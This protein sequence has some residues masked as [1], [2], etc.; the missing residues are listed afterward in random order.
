[1]IL[2]TNSKFS[3]KS[4]CASW[5]GHEITDS[6]HFKSYLQQVV[7]PRLRDASSFESD[8]R[9]LATTGMDTKFLEDVLSSVPDPEGWEI[10]EAMAECILSSASPSVC[11]PW[12]TANDKR[13]PRASLPGTDLVG[14]LLDGQDV[15]LLLGEVKTSSDEDTPP[16]VMYGRG[17]MAWQLEETALRQ[18]IQRTLLQWL[19]VRCKDSPSREYYRRAAQA[20]IR[21]KGSDLILVGLLMRDTKPNELDLKSRALSLATKLASLRQVRLYVY[22]FPTAVTH[23]PSLTLA[24]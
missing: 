23:W 20:F 3:G 2:K 5:E 17:G 13:T 7:K 12:N 22:Y 15:W 19:Y 24:S 8:L 18:D 14:F 4:G 9:A 6:S 21:S 1:M 11:W 16:N 10:G